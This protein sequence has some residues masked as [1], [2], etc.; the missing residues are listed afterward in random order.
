M[1]MPFAS[2]DCL[3]VNVFRPSNLRPGT[4]LPVVC[5]GECLSMISITQ[6]CSYSGRRCRPMPLEPKSD[7]RYSY[8]GGYQ[9][10]TSSIY[11]GSLIV[12]QSVARVCLLRGT[13]TRSSLCNLTTGNTSDLRQLQLS[14]RPSRLS[15]R[16]RRC[17]ITSS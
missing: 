7:L 3:T 2:E 17:V 8:G 1:T 6:S 11:N 10:G 9:S 4:K 15:A 5:P 16:S 13:S 12:A 14:S